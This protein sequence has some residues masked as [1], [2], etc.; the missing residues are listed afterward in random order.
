MA[1][2]LRSTSSIVVAQLD[3]LMRIA[4][5][6]CQTVGPHQQVPS[7]CRRAI[8]RSVFSGIAERDQHLVDD[9]LVQNFKAGLFSPAANRRAW[10]E[11]RSTMAGHALPAERAQAGPQL[12]AAGAAGQLRL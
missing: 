9:H 4:V 7:A 10:L 2:R 3:T 11:V 1:A 6:P 5:R 8:T 12:H